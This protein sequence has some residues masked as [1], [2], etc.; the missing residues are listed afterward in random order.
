M[1][2][3]NIS[4]EYR[5]DAILGQTDANRYINDYKID[6]YHDDN[7]QD[8]IKHDLIGK[9]E[10]SLVLMGLMMNKGVS[11]YEVFDNSQFLS[12]IGQTIIDFDENDFAEPFASEDM[13]GSGNLLVISRIELLPEWRKKGIGRKMIKDIVLRFSGC[14]DLVILK[15]FP[16]QQEYQYAEG[17]KNAWEKQMNIN[18]LPKDVE[19]SNYK[20]FAYYQNLG[21]TQLENTDY[22]YLNL[23]L[24]NRIFDAIDLEE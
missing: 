14:C 23:A 16:L 10:A 19:F 13:G 11:Y 2:Q 17:N 15:A 7:A 3:D 8:P 5:F 9:V 4:I 20:M 21:F 12:E 6:I 1:E 24:Q 22:F 18:D